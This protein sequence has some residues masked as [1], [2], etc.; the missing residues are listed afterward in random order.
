[1]R[2]RSKPIH[3]T[4]HWEGKRT[5]KGAMKGW[6]RHGAQVCESPPRPPHSSRKSCV[7]ALQQSDWRDLTLKP[8]LETVTRQRMKMGVTF[9]WACC[10]ATQQVSQP[11]R[12]ETGGFFLREMEGEPEE[13]IE[14]YGISPI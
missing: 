12:Q 1:M 10:T 4:E 3:P 6:V 7:R 13:K 11:P 2:P 8:R 5:E 14:T 9:R